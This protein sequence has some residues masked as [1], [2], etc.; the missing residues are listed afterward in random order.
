MQNDS[1]KIISFNVNGVLNIVK[2]NKILSKLK[3]EKAQ[4]ALLQETHMSQM[5]HLRLKRKGFKHVFYSSVK[6]KHKRGVATLITGTL[7]YEHISEISD[8]E[9]RFIRITGKIE[10][11]EITI[12]NVY[13]PPGSDWIFYRNIFDLMLDSQGTVICGGDFN[14]RLNPK[15]DSSNPNNYSNSLIKN[16]NSYMI[17]MGI[18]DV[19]RKLHPSNKDFTHYSGSYK[20]YARLDYFFMFSVD[21]FRVRECDILTSDL[22]DHNPIFMSLELDKKKRST[23]WKF[24]S[25]ILN[26]PNVV[27][28]IKEDIREI[29]ET[30]DTG[31]VSPNTLWDTLKVVTR[32]KLF[33]LTSHLKKIKD[34]KLVDLQSNLK[35][36]Q[37]EDITNPN[38]T[39]KQE[40][41]KIQDE[42]NYIYTQE[43]QKKLAFIRQRYYEIGGKSTKYLAYKLRKQQEE[44]TIFQIQN[45]KTNKME[46]KLENIQQ[47]FE[48]FY[49][50]LYS[51]PNTPE[52]G[53]GVY[54]DTLNLP[55]LSDLQNQKLVKPISE[56]EV[57]A[58]I[59]RLKPG[60]A[61]GPDGYSSQWYRCFRIELVPILQKTFNYILQEGVIP[62]SW[63]EATISIIP[64][65]GKDKRDCRNYRPISVLN[66]DYKLFTSIFARRLQ[67]LL[68][69]LINLDQT[70]FIHHRQT[71]DNIRRI[72]HILSKI[73]KDKTQSIIESRR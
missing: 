29:L 28:K 51:Q 26:D 23:M 46:T 72:L 39:L 11:S 18:M 7:G 2:M 15:I 33:S 3:R 60:K 32:G 48:I 34:Q 61:V 41:K 49:R 45:P 37:Q 64:K 20:V 47:C 16:I 66:L 9:G 4:I 27:S 40:I 5:D 65:E 6:S 30:N 8:D 36:K 63:R 50:E 31:E 55:S 52:E 21:R 24:N 17:E 19:W 59:T 1:V 44:S 69:D 68:P 53:M 62:L 35:L 67:L 25:Y 38:F 14:L 12:L 56:Q 13:A 73:Q 22:S 42:I 71:T 10:G 57:N 70:G 43:A 58:A 54:L